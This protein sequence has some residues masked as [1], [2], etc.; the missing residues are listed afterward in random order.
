MRL[1]PKPAKS[2]LQNKFECFRKIDVLT[3]DVKV[4]IC[5]VLIWLGFVVIELCDEPSV[6]VRA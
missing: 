2:I 4:A 5:N 1:E 6:W 3:S